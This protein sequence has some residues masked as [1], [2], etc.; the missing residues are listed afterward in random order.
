[1]RLSPSNRYLIYS[2][3]LLAW[4]SG[5]I[6]FVLQTWWVAAGEFG[7]EAHPW[8]YPILRFHGLIAFVAMIGFGF[9]LGAHGKPASRRKPRRTSGIVFASWILGSII[10]AYLLYYLGDEDLRQLVGYAHLGFGLAAPLV[11]AIHVRQAR[12]Y[13]RR[14]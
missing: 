7:P 8:Q 2:V 12:I 4:C 1:M 11:L 9:V 3:L 10:S 6:F 13:R 14:Q 5:V